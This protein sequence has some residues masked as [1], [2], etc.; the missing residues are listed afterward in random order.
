MIRLVSLHCERVV[1]W[2]RHWE[3]ACPRC[4]QCF[5]V[6]SLLELEALRVLNFIPRNPDCV[7]LR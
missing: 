1:L 4:S 5:S 6:L 7:V 3:A 2:V